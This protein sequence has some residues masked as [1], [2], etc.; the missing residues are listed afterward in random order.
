M[1]CLFEALLGIRFIFLAVSEASSVFLKAHVDHEE[2]PQEDSL[3]A[4]RWHLE[5]L[6]GGCARKHTVNMAIPVFLS[7]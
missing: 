3:S 2:A 4:V 1:S 6:K 7:I 5:E